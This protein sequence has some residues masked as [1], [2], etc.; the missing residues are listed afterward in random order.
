MPRLKPAIRRVLAYVLY[1]TGLLWLLAK[2]RLRGRAVVLMYH[3]VLPPAA[4]SFSHEA[5]VVSPREFDLQM[6]F[7]RRHFQPLTPEQFSYELRNGTFRRRACLV[8]FDDGW[9]DNA[10]H[11]LPVLRKHQ[12]PAL[13]FVAT[14][15]VGT[16]RTFW[17]E[18]LTR[19]LFFATRS[20][21]SANTLR[22]LG[23]TSAV[24]LSDAVA[25]AT[26]RDAVT[27]MKQWEPGRVHE[28][29]QR[30]EDEVGRVPTARN[31]GDD[32]F[33]SWD[34][35]RR[36][37]QS[38][39]VVVGSHAHSHRPLT[40]LGYDG[41]CAE[42]T[43]SRAALATNGFC[44]VRTCAYPNGNVDTAV[45]RAATDSGFELG[46]ATAHGFV[47]PGDDPMRLRRI[48]IGSAGVGSRAEFLSRILQIL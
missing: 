21:E 43:L 14:G 15:Y 46:F 20:S 24:G 40:R 28:L 34:D 7:L 26:V 44:D 39:W 11:A 19:L 6:S 17:Q 18:R 4:A 35:L 1:Y 42:F 27:T 9:K 12:V 45:V 22:E 48:N 41:A 31:L 25:L 36:L 23:L 30:L 5:I 32:T 16:D 29:I 2:F 33:L 8:T 37:Q 38:G 10:E 47:R 3:R 13:V